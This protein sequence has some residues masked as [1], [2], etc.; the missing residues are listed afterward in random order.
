MSHRYFI[1][2][3]IGMV[4]SCAKSPDFSPTPAIVFK[5]F[6]KTTL[7]QGENNDSTFVQLDF[8]DGDG[9][10]GSNVT[11]S[12]PNIFFTDLRTG[13]VYSYKAPFI[14]SQGANNGITGKITLLLRST[15]CIYPENTGIPPCDVSTEFPT[16][17]LQYSIYIQD[18]K[19]NKSNSV[20]TPD[21]ELR[22]Q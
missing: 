12:E 16:N 10:F 9:D 15:C 6:T 7:R 11:S 3:M 19:G 22:C 14:P 5:G 18:R 20:I 1:F 13:V 17:L 2:F 21:L 4:F 8:A